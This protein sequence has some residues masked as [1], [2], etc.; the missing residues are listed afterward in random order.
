MSTCTRSSLYRDGGRYKT[1]WKPEMRKQSY[2]PTVLRRGTILMQLFWDV[3]L[4]S[5]LKVR[6]ECWMAVELP[7]GYTS[8]PGQVLLLQVPDLLPRSSEF[9]SVGGETQESRILKSIPVILCVFCKWHPGTTETQRDLGGHS[10]I[11]QHVCCR[12]FTD[13]VWTEDWGV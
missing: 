3:R 9:Q 12:L 1:G 10:N 4:K 7:S 8:E 13:D 6:G 11:S 5:C 2:V